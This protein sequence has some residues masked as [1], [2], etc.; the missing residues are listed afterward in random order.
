MLI[1]E[2]SVHEHEGT[3]A[4]AVTTEHDVTVRDGD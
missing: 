4:V 3:A 1:I 2:K